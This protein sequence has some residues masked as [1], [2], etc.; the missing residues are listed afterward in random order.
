MKSS[1]PSPR[2]AEERKV[3]RLFSTSPMN[4]KKILVIDDEVS[5]LES[6]KMILEYDG[7]AVSV[8]ENG[9]KGITLIGREAFDAV[10]LDIKMVGLDGFEVLRKIREDKKELPIIMIS[11]HG[12]IE[13]AVEAIKVGATDFLEKPLDRNRLLVSVKNAIEKSLLQSENREMKRKIE[14]AFSPQPILGDSEATR[15]VKLLIDRVAITESRVLITG[16]NGTGKELV[17]KWIHQKSNRAAKPFVEL[18]CAAIPSELI[19]SELFGHE[20][21]SFTGATEQ[22]IG[23]F[24]QANTGTI[25]LDEIGDMSLSAQAKMLRAL[26]ENKVQRV[27]GTKAIDVDVRVLAATNKDLLVEIS[28]GTFRED[29]YHRLS[30]IV[31]HVPPLSERR[32]D[33][34]LIAKAFVEEICEKNNFPSKT[35]TDAALK[36]LG[37]KEWRGNIRELHNVIERLVI[38]SE[39]NKIT[40]ADVDL[41]AGATPTKDAAQKNIFSD[42]DLF[43]DFKAAA[44][45]LFIKGKLDRYRWNISKTAEKIGMQRSHLYTKIER[46]GLQKPASLTDDD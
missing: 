14:K 46:Y 15:R 34:P 28:K 19:E 27:G 40:D 35:I 3:K 44:E 39:G 26:Q 16:G 12:T 20:K 4:S 41:F 11:G 23:K 21:G 17:A 10:L 18:N 38:M 5:I 9:A 43:E 8:A 30:V 37:E 45:A 7:F 33:I 22:R 6:V 24:E 13:T 36:L 29:L 42:Y 2:S 25:F 31:I 1:A 32:D